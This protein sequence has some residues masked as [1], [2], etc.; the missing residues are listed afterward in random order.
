MDEKGNQRIKSLLAI[1]LKT[2]KRRLIFSVII[3]I[4]LFTLLSTFLFTWFNYRYKSFQNYDESYDW[5]NDSDTSIRYYAIFDLGDDAEL[6]LDLAIDELQTTLNAV[7]TDMFDNYTVLM[8]YIL[9]SIDYNDAN[10]IYTANLITLHQE[11]F[12]VL[13][14]RL[15]EGRLPNNTSELLYYSS[16]LLSPIYQL[17]D[18]VGLQST[19]DEIT[20]NQ[21]YTIVGVIDSVSYN[22]YQN[23][24]SNDV[25]QYFRID[26]QEFDQFKMDLFFTYPQY[27]LDIISNYPFNVTGK[28]SLMVDFNYQ[29]DVKDIRNLFAIINEL[30]FIQSHQNFE[31]LPN[32]SLFCDDFESFVIFFQVNWIF[33]TIKVFILGAPII[34]FFGLIIIE[35]FNFGNYEKTAQFKLFKTYGLDFVTL[36]KILFTENLITAS[37]GL[38]PGV[39]LGA[40]IGYAISSLGFDILNVGSYSNAFLE[41]TVYITILALFLFIFIGGFITETLFARRTVRLTSEIFKSKRKKYI[42]RLFTS[43]ESL[44]LITGIITLVIGFLGWWYIPDSYYIVLAVLT[45]LSAFVF[46]MIIGILFTL[47]SLFLILSRLIVIFWRYVGEKVWQRRKNYFT[48]A[49]KQLSIYGKDYKKVIFVMLL[50]CLCISPG[51]VLMKS[52][53]N[54]LEMESNLSV[55]FSDILIQSWVDNNTILMENISVIPGVDLITKVEVIKIR[56]LG[57]VRT[58]NPD[59]KIFDVDVLN[60]NNVSEFIE[61]ISPNFPDQCKYTLADISKLDTNMTYMMSSKFAKKENYDKDKIYSSSKITS[62]SFESYNMSFINKFDYFPLLPYKSYSF[63]ENLLV[64][65]YNLVMSNLTYSQLMYKFDELTFVKNN[66]YILA[67]ITPT[68]NKTL[69]VTEIENL[70]YHIRVTTFE[71]EFNALNLEMNKFVFV[72]LII[73]TIISF[74]LIFF[75][76]FLVARN[77]YKQRMRIIES[78]YNVGVNKHQ[79]WLNF[80][81]ELLLVTIIPLFISAIISSILLYTIYDYFLDIPQTYKNFVPWL[82]VWFIVL[83]ILVCL[84]TILF[85]WLVEMWQQFHKYTPVRQE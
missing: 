75:Y 80:S 4:I 24:F 57:N 65:K 67:K 79:I 18:Q 20:Y 16:D 37:I 2:N 3:S 84:I 33:Q 7:K 72:Y 25:F 51:L 26:Q 43:I 77:V 19:K 6:Y 44:L 50:I 8:N 32:G 59:D 30:N 41:P 68:A 47:A 15:V 48:L 76:G 49:L 9:D 36:R 12:D 38:F 66:T 54:H 13:T 74:S 70:P 81:I 11:A 63:L 61:I 52:S 17:G 56:E 31:Y 29:I 78:E 39:L 14:N 69:L 46:L 62:S 53:N 21:N 34:L 64:D 71:D 5:Y 45:L 35:M 55:G 60:I 42:R 22:L 10:Q 1:F 83:I 85:G 82:P 58:T 73:I 28:L 40:L 23:G 27:F